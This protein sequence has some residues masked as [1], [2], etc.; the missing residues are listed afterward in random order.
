MICW[1]I[2]FEPPVWEI[3]HFYLLF[4]K[5]YIGNKE[6]N[7]QCVTNDLKRRLSHYIKIRLLN[8][9]EYRGLRDGIRPDIEKTPTPDDDTAIAGLV[10][11]GTTSQTRHVNRATCPILMKSP[12]THDACA[13]LIYIIQDHIS[14]FSC[15]WPRSRLDESSSTG[16]RVPVPFSGL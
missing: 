12:A 4:Q 15:F 11:I 3:F 5:Q 2:P 1:K 13:A 14:S 6:F 9:T 10:R 8:G 16:P 7:R